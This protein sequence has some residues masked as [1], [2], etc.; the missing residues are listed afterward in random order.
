[1]IFLKTLDG[2]ERLLVATPAGATVIR[3]ATWSTDGARLAYTVQTG[4]QHDIW[5]L[6]M[7]E[8]PTAKPFLAT[9]ASEYSPKFSPDGRWLAYV[10]DESG[11]FEVYVQPYPQCER[12]SV[13]TTGGQGPVWSG[14][15]RELFFEG[16]A[17]GARKM[18]AVAV[19]P[20]GASLRLGRPMPLFDLR[21]PGPAGGIEEY[22]IVS[23]SGAGYDVLPDGRFVMVR[24]A[25]PSGTREI[26]LVHHWFEE[27]KRLVLRK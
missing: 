10:S 12:L 5:I 17:D 19:T 27:L 7:G 2:R 23:N 14:D 1:M 9:A 20:A 22:A 16:I 26:V 25:D 3:N 6:T 21:V 8:T 15:G 4:F 13:S 18:M 24:G 11:R